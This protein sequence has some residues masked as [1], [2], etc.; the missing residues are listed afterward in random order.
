MTNVRFNSDTII[1]NKFNRQEKMIHE[2]RR[3]VEALEMAQARFFYA[4]NPQRSADKP[5][6]EN[7]TQ[8]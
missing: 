3:R 6:V 1:D 5:E 4:K 8:D 2:L 7:E